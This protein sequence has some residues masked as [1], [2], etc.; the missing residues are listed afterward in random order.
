MYGSASYGGRTV[1]RS[2]TLYDSFLGWP[3]CAIVASLG[4]PSPTQ[5]RTRSRSRKVTGRSLIANERPRVQGR[6][7][8]SPRVSRRRPRGRRRLARPR[9]GRRGRRRIGRGG[10]WRSRTVWVEWTVHTVRTDNTCVDLDRFV[11]RA[12]VAWWRVRDPPTTLGGN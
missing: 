8:R 1:T 9:T 7:P 10:F 5:C 11:E 2:P 6:R 3:A 12:R 4:K